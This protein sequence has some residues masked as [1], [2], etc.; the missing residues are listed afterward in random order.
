[1]LSPSVLLAVLL[2]LVSQLPSP[3]GDALRTVAE[4]TE[5][6]AP[7][8]HVDVVALCRGDLDALEGASG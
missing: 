2:P 6:K 5:Y 7:A 1:M 3:P 8:R 4:R